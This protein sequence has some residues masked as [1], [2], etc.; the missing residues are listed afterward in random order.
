MS[1]HL[2]LNGGLRLEYHKLKG[3]YLPYARPVPPD[4]LPVK[5]DNNW[6]LTR[7]TLGAVLKLTK[8]FGFWAEG[9]YNERVGA[10]ED[11]SGAAEPALK[12]RRTPMGQVGIYFNHSWISLV[13]AY[14]YIRS[15]NYQSRLSLVNPDDP[16]ESVIET[17]YYDI[18]TMGWTTDIVA[19]PFKGFKL[20]FLLTWQNPVYKNYAVT[21]YGQ[22]Y[23]YNNKN[24]GISKVL[25]EIDPSYSFWN[26]KMNIWLSARYFSKQYA[27]LTNVLYFA[28]H[29]E[30][31]G[32]VS[33]KI[34]K[35][36]NVGVSVTN[37]LNQRGA[38][39]SIQGSQLVTDPT[40]FYNTIVVGSYL[41]PFTIGANLDFN[42]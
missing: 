30:T 16:N 37:I 27:N 42:F 2:T 17:V 19:T 35:H 41:I 40:P 12:T 23:D 9:T 11:Y 39:G 25:F 33:Y 3:D 8:S 10:L 34:N 24:P 15:T 4:S 36:L 29:W 14:T 18:S 20:H 6:F 31:F 1:E 22:D 13:S 21:A 28:P 5:F 38:T 32:G 26:D 7:A